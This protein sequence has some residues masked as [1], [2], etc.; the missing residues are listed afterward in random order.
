[1]ID[2]DGITL[3]CAG[4]ILDGDGVGTGIQL[5]SRNFV[6]IMNCD[7]TEFSVGIDIGSSSN[8]NTLKNN[9]T[10]D[11]EDDGIFLGDSNGNTVVGNTANENGVFGI[12]LFHSD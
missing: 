3:N 12:I 7:V 6:T 9:N 4:H 11:N 10:F 2:D 8:N 1:M 5:I